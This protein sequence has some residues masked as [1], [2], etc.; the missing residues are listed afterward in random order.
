MKVT[1]GRPIAATSARRVSRARTGRICWRSGA[2]RPPAGEPKQAGIEMKISPHKLRHTYATHRLDAGTERTTRQTPGQADPHHTP[3]SYP[4]RAGA[5]S[6]FIKLS[7][8]DP[9]LSVA[10]AEESSGRFDSSTVW[11]ALCAAAIAGWARRRRARRRRRQ[12]RRSGRTLRARPRFATRTSRTMT[13]SNRWPVPRCC[14][15]ARRPR[16]PRHFRRMV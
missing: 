4:C 12:Y 7:A 1:D 6:L 3:D 15:T 2:G 16:T 14:T 8:P 5:Q 9:S 11:R 10:S 13:R